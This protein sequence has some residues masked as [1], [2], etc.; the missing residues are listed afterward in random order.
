MKT[1]FVGLG[2]GVGLGMLFA[3]ARG[4]DTR[5]DVGVRHSNAGRNDGSPGTG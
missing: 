4:E 2:V 5:R 1:F 3:P